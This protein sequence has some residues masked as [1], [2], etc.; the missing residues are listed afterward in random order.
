MSSW[1]N[2]QILLLFFLFHKL[3][4]NASDGKFMNLRIDFGMIEKKSLKIEKVFI[5]WYKTKKLF[6]A[7]LI[8]IFRQQINFFFRR[9]FERRFDSKRQTWHWVK[10]DLKLYALVDKN[11]SL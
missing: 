1:K 2:M 7:N 3:Q 5:A 9:S 4:L 10:F 11:L 8:Q 6:Y